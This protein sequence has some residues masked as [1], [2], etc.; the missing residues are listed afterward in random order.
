[1]HVARRIART[2]MAMLP[3]I[4]ILLPKSIST[5]PNIDGNFLT[6]YGNLYVFT[7]TIII[8]LCMFTHLCETCW[9]KRTNVYNMQK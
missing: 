6:T 7:V 3:I 2:T 9:K 5:N 8:G 4:P 1:M